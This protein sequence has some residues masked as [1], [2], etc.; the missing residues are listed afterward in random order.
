MNIIVLPNTLS[1]AQGDRSNASPQ[2]TA[3]RLP[4]LLFGILCKQFCSSNHYPPPLSLCICLTV[5]P[6]FNLILFGQKKSLEGEEQCLCAD[7]S[8]SEP[9]LISC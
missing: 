8:S 3:D 7:Q 2:Q 1:R 4:V 6:A 5:L 9:M